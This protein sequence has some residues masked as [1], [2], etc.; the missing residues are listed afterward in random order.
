MDVHTAFLNGVQEEEVYTSQPEGYRINSNVVC[1]LN[2]YIYGLK[3][4]VYVWNNS[5]NKLLV[6][7]GFNHLKSDNC[8]YKNFDRR[9]FVATYVDDL[10]IISTDLVS[11]ECIKKT[12]SVTFD[13][14]DFGEC[15][16]FLD[17]NIK[18]DLH[19]Q[20]IS[21]DQTTYL[22]SVLKR[23]L[24]KIASHLKHPWNPV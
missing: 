5:C 11:I 17:L 10:L 3:Q 9:L 6:K 24:W 2:K 7:N 8:V 4:A 14:E 13:M 23:F 19:G 18:R 15:K 1:K 21:I 12:L 22:N 16:F 20:I